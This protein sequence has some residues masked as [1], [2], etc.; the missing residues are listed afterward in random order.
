MPTPQNVRPR[1]ATDSLR[2]IS[3]Q[4]STNRLQ[5]AAIA[6]GTITASGWTKG[7]SGNTVDESNRKLLIVT[8]GGP[9]HKELPDP[10]NR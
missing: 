3:H 2:A 6:F 1:R 7:S 9:A 4:N 8:L 10:T 5:R